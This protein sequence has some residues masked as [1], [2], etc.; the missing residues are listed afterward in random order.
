M[1]DP[2]VAEKT[3]ASWSGTPR[4]RFMIRPN[5]RRFWPGGGAR[6]SAAWAAILNHAHNRRHRERRGFFGFFESVDDPL[7]A[8]GLLG[9]ARDWVARR[10]IT[11]M[12]GPVNPSMNY[13]CGLLVDG[14]DSPPTFMMTYNPPYYA[15][16]IESCGFRK[17]QDLYA[18]WGHASM[19]DSL[20]KKLDFIIA[21]AKRRFEIRL[22]TLE[23]SRFTDEVQLFLN[24]YNESLEGTWGFVPLSGAEIQHI[25]RGLRHLIVPQLTSVAEV[26]G[27]PVAAVFGLLDYNPRIKQNR[28][29]AVPVWLLEAIVESPENRSRAVDQHKRR[30]GVPALGRG[31][32]GAESTVAGRPG[33]GHPRGR[34]FVGSGKQP[35]VAR[36]P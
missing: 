27:R 19:L 24:I 2:A 21:E 28:W 3:S 35:P 14:F 22:R 6:R 9:A 13:E 7:V 8:G 18:F 17:S 20:D 23:T 29:P 11:Q 26:D 34:V 5:A 12:R 33:V 36:L 32:R 10:D 30:P 25:S 31:G 1:L 15:S 4:I 16:L